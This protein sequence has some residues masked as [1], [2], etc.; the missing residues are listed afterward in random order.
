[1]LIVA[2]PSHPKSL[3]GWFA[4]FILAL[5]VTLLGEVIGEGLWQN[6]LA[7]RI[8]EKTAGQSFSWWRI[9]YGFVAMLLVFAV[10]WKLAIWFGVEG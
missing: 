4:F 2:F 5:P 6:R 8:E 10:A 7:R 3:L 1:M 9:T